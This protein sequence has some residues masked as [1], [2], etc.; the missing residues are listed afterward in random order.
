MSLRH[1]DGKLF[2]PEAEKTREA[3]LGWLEKLY[4]LNKLPLSDTEGRNQMLKSM[5]SS[6]GEKAEIGI[7]FFANWAGHFTKIG[8]N[9]IAGEGLSLIEEGGITIGNNVKLGR[10]VT[11]ITR[12]TPEDAELRKKGYMIKDGVTIGD[13]CVIGDGCLILP[14]SVIGSGCIVE[15][16][17]VV[18]DKFPDEVHLEGNPAV[19]LGFTSNVS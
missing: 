8:S 12:L 2:I 19:V 5:F 4:E 13:N 16:G 18:K 1:Y 11:I 6:L 9:F 17:S 14:G 15:A 3:Q 7:P 10:N